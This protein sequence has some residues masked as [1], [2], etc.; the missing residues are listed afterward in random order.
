MIK[1]HKN[2][3]YLYPNSKRKNMLSLAVFSVLVARVT[4]FSPGLSDHKVHVTSSTRIYNAM[5]RLHDPSTN[6]F[7]PLEHIYSMAEID[8]I[9]H[10]IEDDE[11]MALGSAIA[12][13]MLE[14]ILDVCSGVLKKMGWVEKMNVI[15]KVAQ[16]ISKTVEVSA[17]FNLIICISHFKT[18][19]GVELQKSLHTIRFQ[20]LTFGHG[21]YSIPNELLQP[22]Y[23][24]VRQELRNVSGD[25]SFECNSQNLSV[26][27]VSSVGEAIE[28][29]LGPVNVNAPFFSLS[30]EMQHRISSRRKELLVKHSKGYENVKDVE[31]DIED[32]RKDWVRVNL[33]RKAANNYHFGEVTTKVGPGN[34][35]VKKQKVPSIWNALIQDL[36]GVLLP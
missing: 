36:D 27:V 21:Q 32:S 31:R 6:A 9:T 26:L 30:K 22:L 25:E 15:N 4:A 17:T 33:G 1:V 18:L 34:G 11:W 28:S 29:Y 10:K 20:S 2:S 8:G 14:T 19:I 35:N 7:G 3:F 16:D 24:I 12:E 13:S 23:K 5:E